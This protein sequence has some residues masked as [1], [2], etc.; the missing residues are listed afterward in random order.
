MEKLRQLLEYLEKHIDLD[1]CAE[2]E[3]RYHRALSFEVI[4]KP[5]L[6]ISCDESPLEFAPFSY[7]GTFNDPA[8]MM[9]NQLLSRVAL[10]IVLKDDSPL[11]IRNDHGIIQ[12]GSLLGGKWRITEDNYPW[13]EHF[14]THDQLERIT[15]GRIKID[16]ESGGIVERSV[17]T[18]KFYHKMLAKYPVCQK[19]I[20]VSMPDLQGPMDTAHLLWGNDIFCA[21]Y[22]EGEFF[23]KF[24]DTVV[25]AMLG[26]EQ[27]YR[28]LTNDR[29]GP[30]AMTQHT[31]VIPGRILIRDDT[32]IMLSPE[33]YEKQI[34]PHNTKI[35]DEIG[36]GSIHLC[37][38]GEHL[39]DAILEAPNVAG[40]DL[41]QPELMDIETIYV[42]CASKKI[43]ITNFKRSAEDLI[44]GK[45]KDMFPTGVVFVHQA[46]TLQEAKE[47]ANAYFRN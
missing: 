14:E 19:A 8:K 36:K 29:M 40:V 13:L 33:M 9:F 10:G 25:T 3:D 7:S 20:Q 39:I 18:L 44:S 24:L 12:V 15:D 47:V 35:L 45:A 6:V 38:N 2:I 37:G 28:P 43:P 26:L 1:R 23:S 16:L 41:S 30:F 4:D 22:E 32:S 27:V 11:G 5:P 46:A 17:K 34:L 31:Y 42:K 21:L